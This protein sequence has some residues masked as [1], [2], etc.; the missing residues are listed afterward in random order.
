MNRLYYDVAR[1][2]YSLVLRLRHVDPIQ[3]LDPR[4][5]PRRLGSMKPVGAELILHLE[6]N[7]WNVPLDRTKVGPDTA[8]ESV[9]VCRRTRG[10]EGIVVKVVHYRVSDEAWD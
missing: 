3:C 1:K 4:V 2:H 9:T 7:E 5:L 10:A 8:T 6:Q